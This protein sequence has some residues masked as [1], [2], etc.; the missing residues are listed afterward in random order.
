MHS[1][2]RLA[3]TP[4]LTYHGPLYPYHLEPL[5]TLLRANVPAASA[6][7]GPVQQF[8]RALLHYCRA[9]PSAHTRNR[10]QCLVV[11]REGVGKPSG[12]S[13]E[14]DNDR[15]TVV[16][17]LCTL[18]AQAENDLRIFEKPLPLSPA[19]LVSCLRHYTATHDSQ[20]EWLQLC[21]AAGDSF[22]WFRESMGITLV[23]RYPD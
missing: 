3:P 19:E 17:A 22:R 4:L 2:P 10:V 16:Q 15:Q 23:C 13:A 11:W 18:T 12:H 1:P 8:L 5:L 21:L 6:G 20:A 9:W 14:T 7:V